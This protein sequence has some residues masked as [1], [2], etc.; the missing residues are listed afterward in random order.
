MTPVPRLRAIILD[1]SGTTVDH[2]CIA[3]AQVF[4]DVFKQHGVEVTP[5]EVRRPMGIFKRDHIRTMT[6][7]PRLKS[8]WR[9]VHGR[10]PTEADVDAMYDAYTPLQLAIVAD[11]ADLIPG[12]LEAVA[13]FRARGLKVGSSTGFTRE[14]M[15][16]LLPEAA[17]QGYEPDALF[18]PDDVG[19]GRPEPWMCFANLRALGVFPPHAAVKIGD[20]VADVHEGLNAGMWT[21]ALAKTGNEVGL[22]LAGWNAL[23]APEQEERLGR[24]RKRLRDAG[25]H[26]VVDSLADAVPLLDAIETR[27]A[28][29]ERP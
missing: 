11:H 27:L 16:P 22:S 19:A 7:E 23:P 4:I 3:P 5:E 17:K 10:A 8:R 21:V 15:T 18:C 24:A 2:G 1:W 25:A 6:E 26:Y 29:G 13:A 12:A 20:T 9:R 28:A 14:M